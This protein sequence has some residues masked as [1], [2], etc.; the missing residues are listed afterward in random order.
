MEEKT[1]KRQL[2]VGRMISS[3][4]IASAILLI[5]LLFTKVIIYHE[6][7]KISAKNEEIYNS[8][9]TYQLQTELIDD[10]CLSFN[11]AKISTELGEMGNFL[12]IIEKKLGKDDP[13]VLNQKKLYTLLQIQHMLLIKNKNEKC[14]T[15]KPIILFF[16]SNKENF[17]KQA[18]KMGYILSSYK[19]DNLNSMIYSFDYNLDIEAIK[20]LK[21][22]HGITTANQIVISGKVINDLDHINDI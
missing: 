1:E 15:E 5:I 21:Q 12:T 17:E 10:V 8:I 3:L 13:E 4:L 18:E 20:T 2:Y 16:Y 19:K 22:I 7:S 14:S 6:S 11:D 9:I